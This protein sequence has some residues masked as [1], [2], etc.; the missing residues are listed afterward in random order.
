MWGFIYKYNPTILFRVVY[1]LSSSINFTDIRG[2]LFRNTTTGQGFTYIDDY[3]ALLANNEPSDVIN[4]V[5]IYQIH[6]K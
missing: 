3:D 4:P 2:I 1:I 6:F 5:H